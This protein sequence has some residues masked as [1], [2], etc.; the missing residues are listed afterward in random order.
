MSEP[1]SHE[2]H[3]QLAVA[4][5]ALRLAE[6]RATAGRLALEVMH[7][8]KNPLEAL[9]HLTFLTLEEADD[10]EKVR[11]YMLEA[12]EQ[13]AQLREI[14][15]QTL[16]VARQTRVPKTS[17]L[18]ALAEAA[19]RIH[20]K[21]ISEKKIHLVKD[22]TEGITASIYTSE[23]LQVISNLIMNALDALP[24]AGVLCLRVRKRRDEVHLVVADTGHG[25]D[26]EHSANIF[27]PFFTTKEERGT[28]LGLA[29]SKKIVERHRGRISMRS[30]VQPGKSGTIFRIAL[31]A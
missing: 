10:P 1:T 26:A 27:K 6:E 28:G 25:I 31:P 5:E 2:L 17:D 18:A 13:M 20:Q 3:R 12:E 16:G 19:I 9:S 4:V 24:P 21:T 22:I 7:E 23:I 14:A 8:I 29:L 15:S 30:R 11:G